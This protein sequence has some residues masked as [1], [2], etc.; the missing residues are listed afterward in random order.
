MFVEFTRSSRFSTSERSNLVEKCDLSEV[1]NHA[2][3]QFLQI[4]DLSEVKLSY[5]A[6]ALRLRPPIWVCVLF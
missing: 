2:G 1:E 6:F 4:H 3:L 5:N